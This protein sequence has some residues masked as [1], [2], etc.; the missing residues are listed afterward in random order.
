MSKICTKCGAQSRDSAA[1]CQS[2]G[3]NLETSSQPPPAA[4]PYTSP[5]AYNPSPVYS[6]MYAPPP[7]SYVPPPVGGQKVYSQSQAIKMIKS[8]GSSLIFLIVAVLFTA[9]FLLQLIQSVTLFS[10]QNAL[11]RAYY[12]ILRILDL[13]GNPDVIHTIQDLSGGIAAGNLLGLILPLLICAGMWMFFAVC[14]RADD[15]HRST[16]GLTMI[17]VSVMIT[18]IAL[19]VLFGILEILLII[20]TIAAA[21][22]SSGFNLFG[23]G[24][25]AAVA[26]TILVVMIFLMAGVIVLL[27]CYLGGLTR[28]INAAV[29]GFRTGAVTRAS[30]FLAVMNIIMA[31]F[32]IGSSLLT[33][34]FSLIPVL[35]GVING[36]VLIL[37]SVC[38]IMYNRKLVL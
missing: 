13:G 23:Y 27:A 8:V 17:K 5:P 22:A 34:A 31:V 37:A 10:S 24:T 30:M 36:A 15:S 1:F 21:V 25:E 4:P 6:P 14:R 32:G 12:D 29:N 18:N 33:P 35:T 3:N 20:A 9:G 28:T 19:L 11:L 16:A 26:I 2:C 7:G 38:I